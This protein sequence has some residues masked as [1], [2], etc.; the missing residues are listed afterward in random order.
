MKKKVRKNKLNNIVEKIFVIF[1]LGYGF[2]HN[3]YEIIER[4]SKDIYFE[5]AGTILTLITLGK[6]L[7]ARS[8]GKTKDAIN[9]LINL[10]PKTAIVFPP[11][12]NAPICA[13]VSI[14]FAIPLIIVRPYFTSPFV[15]VLH[16]FSLCKTYFQILDNCQSV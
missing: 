3:Q 1:M 6:Y 15:K 16:I 11:A 4:Y 9:K 5:S 12:F 8:K 2:G 7:E 14:P 10:A 13:A